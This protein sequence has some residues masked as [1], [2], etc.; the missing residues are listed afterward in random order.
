WTRAE[1][2]EAACDQRDN[3]DDGGGNEN[4]PKMARR[5]ACNRNLSIRRCRLLFAARRWTTGRCCPASF[6]RVFLLCGSRYCGS[7]RLRFA[8]ETLQVGPHFR[9]DLIAQ[10]A[11]FL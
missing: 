10:V 3:C 6:F 1:V 5:L 7:A 11:V 9:G 8:L 2:V 4:L